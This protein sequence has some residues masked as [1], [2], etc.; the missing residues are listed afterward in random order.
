[1]TGM[2]STQ[3][4]HLVGEGGVQKHSILHFSH[5]GI[6]VVG[7]RHVVVAL[8]LEVVDGN[9]PERIGNPVPCDSSGAGVGPP[10]PVKPEPLKEDAKPVLNAFKSTASSSIKKPSVPARTGGGPSVIPIQGL[11]PYSNK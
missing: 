11:S 1:M 8:S 6:N 5:Y 3:L 4:N 7:D 10:A 2:L 9:Y